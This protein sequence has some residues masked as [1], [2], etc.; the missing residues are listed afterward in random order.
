[1]DNL[2]VMSDCEYVSIPS[3]HEINLKNGGKVSIDGPRFPLCVHLSLALR[4]G[5]M[6]NLIVMSDCDF[7]AHNL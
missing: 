6:D 7:V 5:L 1:M 2:I 4:L 3:V